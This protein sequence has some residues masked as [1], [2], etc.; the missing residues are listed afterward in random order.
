VDVQPVVI[1][2]LLILLMLANGMPVVAK[3][4][5]GDDFAYPFDGG[6]RFRTYPPQRPVGNRADLLNAE[7]RQLVKSAGNCV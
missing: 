2:Q 1:I 4:I 3:D 7:R 6:V 5:L